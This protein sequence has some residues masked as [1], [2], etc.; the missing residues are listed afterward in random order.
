MSV[1]TII[2]RVGEH[3]LSYQNVGV[4][5]VCLKCIIERLDLRNPF[6]VVGRCA[7]VELSGPAEELEELLRSNETQISFGLVIELA[8]TVGE[9]LFVPSIVNFC[10]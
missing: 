5:W 2:R 9:E 6:S 3:I 10:L 1:D 4:L 8:P 7:V